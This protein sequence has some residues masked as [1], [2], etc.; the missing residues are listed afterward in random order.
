[1]ARL[2]WNYDS[3]CIFNLVGLQ[4]CFLCCVGFI[5]KPLVVE[6][7]ANARTESAKI[8]NRRIQKKVLFH[9]VVLAKLCMQ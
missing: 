9:L 6:A 1:M 3:A 4:M 7:R 2:V 8:R 5:L